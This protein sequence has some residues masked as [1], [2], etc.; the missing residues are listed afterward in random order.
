MDSTAIPLQPRP[1][2][3]HVAARTTVETAN[4]P[5]T[6]SAMPSQYALFEVDPTISLYG[7]P[8]GLSLLFSTDR[9]SQEALLERGTLGLGDVG[10][11]SGLGIRQRIDT[12]VQTLEKSQTEMLADS[13][14]MVR[15][16][17]QRVQTDLQQLY[18]LQRMQ[19]PT[20]NSQELQRLGLLTQAERNVLAIPSFGFGSV[21]PNYG[22]LFLSAVTLKGGMVEYNPGR[23]Y[24]ALAAG[25]TPRVDVAL[26]S[27]DGTVAE[28]NQD[29][30]TARVGIG[31]KNGTHLILSGLYAR[32]DRQSQAIL[33]LADPTLPVAAQENVVFGLAGRARHKALVLDADVQA[34]VF[35][36]DKNAPEAQGR[37]V[38]PVLRTLFG[39]LIREGSATDWSGELRGAL[40]LKQAKAKILSSLRFVGP[41]YVTAGARALR[42]DNLQYNGSWDQSWR[43]GR[44]T[45]GALAGIDRTGLVVPQSGTATA[46]RVGLRAVGRPLHLPSLELSYTRNGQDQKAG[47][48][49]T[50]I[51]NRSNLLSARLRQAGRVGASR[52]MTLFMM[53]RLVGTSNDTSGAY[54]STSASVTGMLSLPSRLGLVARASHSDTRTD[55]ATDR[56][57]NVWSGEGSLNW[58]PND[59]LDGS[60]GAT[61][62]T[63]D[64]LH[65]MGGFVAARVGLGAIGAL[66]VQWSYNDGQSQTPGVN[67]FTD[68]VFRVQ[69]LTRGRPEMAAP[70]AAAP[71][72]TQ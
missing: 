33:G 43:Q 56:D 45:V 24:W 41:G 62:A 32:D 40:N 51:E 5:G 20:Q 17:L 2:E 25:T 72:T 9:G 65:Q 70:V 6:L 61:F 50:Q 26:V 68:R 19:E 55:L 47:G 37:P 10:R 18:L 48:A 31:R 36:G 44:L 59:R 7:S 66:D 53:D 27:P 63:S 54:T 49:V 64:G 58:A 42:R 34:S 71:V 15:E 52:Y 21:S 69:F 11:G 3:W 4:R 14:R 8:L 29:L 38:P 23:L 46:T 16:D 13:A 12:R 28:L 30:Y 22:T 60:A 39:G 57:P 67:G 1:V 35:S